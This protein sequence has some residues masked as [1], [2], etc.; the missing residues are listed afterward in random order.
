MKFIIAAAIL[1]SALPMPARA[2]YPAYHL[3]DICKQAI[4]TS[5]GASAMNNPGSERTNMGFCQ[6]MVMAY[7]S[8]V[9]RKFPCVQHSEAWDEDIREFIAD[10]D[11]DP[12]LPQ[13]N[14]LDALAI[15]MVHRHC[16]ASIAHLKAIG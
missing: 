1:M 6:G 4:S 13:A 15:I 16:W 10:L 14:A 7:V 5:E 3:R 8:V 2:E 12:A 9:R 11:L